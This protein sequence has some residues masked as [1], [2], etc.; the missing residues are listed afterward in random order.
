MI[1]EMIVPVNTNQMHVDMT[2]SSRG[3]I[4]IKDYRVD[5]VHKSVLLYIW[6]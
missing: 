3:E 1:A 5:V 6:L 2:L 4:L